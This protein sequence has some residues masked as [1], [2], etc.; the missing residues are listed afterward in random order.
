MQKVLLGGIE[1]QKQER[2][3]SQQTKKWLYVPSQELQKEPRKV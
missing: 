2:H 3:K 1:T